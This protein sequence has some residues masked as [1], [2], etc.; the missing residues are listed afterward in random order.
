M[1]TS[2]DLHQLF[3]QLMSLC[4]I[5]TDCFCT[6]K[7]KV[8]HVNATC[9]ISVDLPHH[10]TVDALNDIPIYHNMPSSHSPPDM[11]ALSLK[12]TRGM[13]VNFH[14]TNLPPIN[15]TRQQIIANALVGY[16]NIVQQHITKFPNIPVRATDIFDVCVA[17]V[18]EYDD[19]DNEYDEDP[20]YIITTPTYIAK[21]TYAH[22][23]FSAARIL[24]LSGSAK[25]TMQMALQ[26]LLEHS[27]IGLGASL[28]TYLPVREGCAQATTGLNAG[29]ALHEDTA[30]EGIAFAEEVRLLAMD[31][32]KT[33]E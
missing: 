21:L 29:W 26:S 12:A 28:D 16:P 31:F 33:K 11:A 3:V 23:K 19:D 2:A 30:K 25:T 4:C 7:R 22:E 24:L 13:R 27:A 32:D 14:N 6:P 20:D 9:H 1:T 18:T 5:A 15:D 17:N 8:S 10:T